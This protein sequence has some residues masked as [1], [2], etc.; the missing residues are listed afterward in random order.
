MKVGFFGTPELAARVM[1][2]LARLHDIV[3]AVT[4][5]DKAAGRNRELRACEA[6]SEALRLGIPVLQPS[7]LNDGVFME[8][9][10][11]HAAD[12]FVVV[13][14][15]SLIPRA[16]FDH[17]PLGT[18][19]LHPSLLPKYRGAAP[20]QWALINGE[21]ETG[22]TVQLINERLDAGDIVLQQTVPLTGDMNA[23]G[24][25]EIVISRGAALLD[26]AIRLLA[27]GNAVPVKQD[28]SKATHCGKIDRGVAEI[29]W[30]KPAHDIHN[31]VRALNPK[32]G[33]FSTFRGENIKIWK[34]SLP[35]G[36]LPGGAV[37]GGIIRHQKKRLLAGT[38]SGYIE[39][40]L[41]QPANKK[42]MD[43]LSFINGYRL[44]P[45]DRFE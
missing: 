33:A 23:A 4:A 16:V 45:D 14:Y 41:L 3:F 6:K 1:A 32:P 8:A 37:P 40:L 10:R 39:I 31:L 24:L 18:L 42:V 19:N 30:G 11:G 12:I 21:A 35:S 15:G 25:N 26:E 9:I 7:R 44:A 28:E 38:G 29:D 17:P 27:S 34:T 13:A 43:G 36:D 22:I 2:D 20:I 5:E